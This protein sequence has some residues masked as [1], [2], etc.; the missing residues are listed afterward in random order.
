MHALV[1]TTRTKYELIHVDIN[2]LVYMNYELL[3]F[4]KIPY[5]YHLFISPVRSSSFLLFLYSKYSLS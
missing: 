3:V 2:Y 4:E 5:K 1:T